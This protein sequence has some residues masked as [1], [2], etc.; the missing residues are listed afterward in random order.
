MQ[1]RVLSP[2]WSSE[3]DHSPLQQAPPPAPPPACRP[4]GPSLWL[5]SSEVEAAALN[6]AGHCDIQFKR[7]VSQTERSSWQQKVRIQCTGLSVHLK[8]Q[9]I[10][11]NQWESG[12]GGETVES[13][14]SGILY[15]VFCV[16]VNMKG[17]FHVHAVLSA[18]FTAWNNV[19]LTFKTSSSDGFVIFPFFHSIPVFIL[20][21]CSDIWLRSR[22]YV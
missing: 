19:R 1:R 22:K 5:P 17:I 6:Q 4:L 18:S 10:L 9:W 15:S 12:M 13:N 14:S 20:L 16:H 2:W 11:T 3:A 7:S 8:Q 21:V